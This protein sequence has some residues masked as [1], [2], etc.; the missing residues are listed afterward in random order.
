MPDFPGEGPTGLSKIRGEPVFHHV[1]GYSCP[2]G[3]A[4]RTGVRKI[5]QIVLTSMFWDRKIRIAIL[6]LATFAALC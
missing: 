4:T 2:Y 1:L 6:T 3:S 5:M